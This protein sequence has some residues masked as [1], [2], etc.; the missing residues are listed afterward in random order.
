M[1]ITEEDTTKMAVNIQERETVTECIEISQDGA[2]GKFVINPLGRGFGVTLGNSLRRVLLSSIPGAAV[3]SIKIQGVLHEMSTIPGVKE[4]V[5]EIV[6]NIK[7]LCVKLFAEEPKTLFIETSGKKTV[8][9]KDIKKDADVEIINKN[10]HIATLDGDSNFNIEITVKPG[11]GY[12]SCDQNKELQSASKPHGS[13]SIGT[14]HV[15]SIYTPI[16]KVSYFVENTRVGQ[17]TDYDKLTVEIWT[18]GTI[19]ADQALIQASDILKEQVTVFSDIKYVRAEDA[20]RIEA[21]NATDELERLLNKAL[22]ELNL[23][24]RSYNC[25]KRAGIDTVRDLATKT[26]TE[27]GKIRNLGSKSLEEVLDKLDELGI[28]LPE[29]EDD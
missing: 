17:D 16:R 5:T 14:I 7:N 9:A 27:M 6:L 20:T 2:Y 15:D 18:N 19:S 29:S 3:T 22:E 12:I 23:T 11:K 13:S 10:L 4:D 8:T 25:L 28:E 1:R 26:L 21:S 24:V